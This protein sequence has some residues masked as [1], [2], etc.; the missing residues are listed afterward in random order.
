MLL[1]RN[2]G[3]VS[4]N[5]NKIFAYNSRLD[6]VQAVVALHL[7]KK[8]NLIT[9]KRISNSLYLDKELSKL[10]PITTKKRKDY[11]KEV[12]HL[13]EFRVKDKKVRSSLVN[14]LIKNNIDAKIH[15]PIPMHLQPAAKKYKYKKGDF[16]TTEEIA[17]TTVSL[18]V[19]EFLSEDKIN[20]MIKKIKDF[21]NEN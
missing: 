9:N 20:F 7:L 1:L 14:Y 19:H 15:Y 8:I 13:Y 6:T 3:L 11:L 2:H 18:P 16:P 5:I 4:R 17:D 21:Y 10:S 12:F